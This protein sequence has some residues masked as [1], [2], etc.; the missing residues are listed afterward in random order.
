MRFTR[1]SLLFRLGLPV[2]LTALAVLVTFGIADYRRE[3]SAH[4]R[5]LAERL[6]E[7]GKVLRVAR[8]Q[9]PDAASFQQ[10][11]DEYCRQMEQHISPGHHIILADERGR[12]VARAHARAD[13]ALEVEMAVLQ[14]EGTRRFRHGD[15]E[16]MVVGVG[17]GDDAT[18][19]V[20]QSLRPVER[21]VN[22]QVVNRAVTVAVLVMLVMAVTNVLLWRLVRRP[23]GQLMQAVEAIRNR[24]FDHRIEQLNTAEL[25]F[26]ADGFKR[27]GAELERVELSR[28]HEMGKARRIHLGLLP[29]E[30]TTIPGLSLAARY[31]SADSVG[32]DYYDMLKYQDGRWLIL[33]ADVSG[34]GV[35]AALVMAMIK[36]LSR[37][38]VAQ[39][40]PML[41]IVRLLNREL[42]S[43]T[44][45][46]HFVTFLA[47][48]YDPETF[49]LQHV[50]CG[51]EPGV[52]FG[53]DGEIKYHLQTSGLPLGVIS[54]TDWEI[55]RCT[56]QAGDRL[57]LVT[58]GLIE[59]DNSSG[60]MLG[61]NRLAQLLSSHGKRSPGEAVDEI[62]AQIGRFRGKDSFE[63]D[64]TL[65]TLWRDR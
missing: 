22:R 53:P 33:I 13:S 64:A 4:L 14:G 58:D 3:R 54:D 20:A 55:G 26:L 42:E 49:E 35:S 47:G 15:D 16:F 31:R 59:V 46:Q 65:V 62:I 37:Q 30:S 19:L 29:P 21:F 32:G 60:E 18:I 9:L 8:R 50:N 44:G 61:R 24:R 57:Y 45:S 36:A 52:V 38:A 51:H 7:E 39:D 11:V 40:R 2:N 28:Q 10:Y 27:M 25:Q 23:V 34:H 12:V 43:L 1:D 48:Q 63:D 6:R 56:L 17:A 5:E 41:D